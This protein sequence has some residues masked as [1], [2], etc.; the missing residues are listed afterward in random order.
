MTQSPLAPILNQS[1]AVAWYQL[2]QF[3]GNDALF[4]NAITAAFGTGADAGQFQ[5]AWAKGD[6]SGFPPIEVRSFAEIN[7][8]NGAFSITT[9]KIYLAQEFVEANVNNLEVIAAVLL[10]EYG[11][12]VDSQINVSD[13]AGDE[14]DIFA[15]LVQGESISE[16]E[17]AVLK[18]ED[19]NAT[20]TVDGQVVEIE[21]ASPVNG[22]I[23]TV[24]TNDDLDSANNM[25]GSLR[26][27]IQ[28]A[29]SNPGRDTINLNSVSGT[30]ILTSPLGNLNTNND[31]DF[32]D[33]GNTIISGD[34]KYQILSVYGAKVSIAGLTFANGYAKGGNGFW[35]G[36]GGLGAGGALFISSGVVSLLD[37]VKFA[38]NKAE[39]GYT[40]YFTITA[41]GGNGGEYYGTNR[42]GDNGTVG[43]NGGGLNGGS[44]QSGQG[45]A[46]GGAIEANNGA[47][48]TNGTGGDFGVGGGGGGGGGG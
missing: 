13:S 41:N 11:H 17:L 8:A 3:A 37:N 14:G 46:A 28:W 33:D 9:G 7:G 24:S 4:G 42:N 32:S 31:I 21:Q 23:Y 40:Y 48:G 43:G 35:G 36:G 34:N 27:A 29:A 15:Q 5:E 47:S 12:Y 16:S 39:G 2:E 1:L 26:D 25:S 6:F 30:I 18:A 10:E 22:S 38:N 20:V 19:D 44:T 45:G